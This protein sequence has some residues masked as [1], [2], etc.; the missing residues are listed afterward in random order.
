MI[1]PST[2]N[3]FLIA[4]SA[5]ASCVNSFT[6]P[7]TLS[8]STATSSFPSTTNKF[9]LYAS[10]SPQSPQSSQSTSSNTQNNERI[11]IL[12][13]R[14]GIMEHALELKNEEVSTYQRR[15]ILLQDVVKKL[16]V[17]NRNLLD[18]IHELQHEKEG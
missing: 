8:L 12:Q 7:T 16:Q 1:T 3:L 14:N 15:N 17:S 13:T 2:L 5:Q 10:S 4:L 6:A 11:S 9:Q 18:K